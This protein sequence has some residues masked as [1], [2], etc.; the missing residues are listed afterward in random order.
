M[1]FASLRRE[2]FLLGPSRGQ[3]F[4]RGDFLVRDA[5]DRRNAG[6]HFLAVDQN[7]TGSALCESAAELRTDQ[8]K[9][10]AQN[11]EQ[12]SV[13]GRLDLVPDSIHIQRDHRER[14]PGTS[15]FSDTESWESKLGTHLS[16]ARWPALDIPLRDNRD[17]DEYLHIAAY[18]ARNVDQHLRWPSGC[19]I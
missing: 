18:L 1:F 14:P 15:E 5:R 6:T 3:T 12:R 16:G 7:G 8:F 2:P 19:V 4:E 9:I 13:V 17:I 10:V 11:V